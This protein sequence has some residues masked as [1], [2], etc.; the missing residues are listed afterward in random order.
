[1]LALSSNPFHIQIRHTQRTG[2]SDVNSINPHEGIHYGLA[3]VGRYGVAHAVA[4]H[5]H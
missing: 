4:C 2:L 5:I 1:M 3:A